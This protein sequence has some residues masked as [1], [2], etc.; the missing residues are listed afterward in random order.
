MNEMDGMAMRVTKFKLRYR[1]ATNRF[2][3]TE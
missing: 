2:N 1:T 3:A